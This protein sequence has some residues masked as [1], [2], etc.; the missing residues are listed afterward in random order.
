VSVNHTV[1]GGYVM[2]SRTDEFKTWSKWFVRDK[3]MCDVYYYK[4]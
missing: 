4:S 1:G 3:I 2:W